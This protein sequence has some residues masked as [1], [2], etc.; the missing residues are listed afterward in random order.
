MMADVVNLGIERKYV[1]RSTGEVSFALLDVGIR[2]SLRRHDPTEDDFDPSW[3][4]HTQPSSYLETIATN[5][6]VSIVA[7][8]NP[9]SQHHGTFQRRPD[10]EVV[11]SASRCVVDPSSTSAQTNIQRATMMLP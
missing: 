7:L 4:L 11:M 5:G 1:I 10:D 2:S 3:P 6:G 9:L 8:L